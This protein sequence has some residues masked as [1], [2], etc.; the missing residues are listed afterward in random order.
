MKTGLGS[1]NEAKSDVKFD[2]GQVIKVGETINLEVRATPGHTE[3]CITYVGNG[4]TLE[5]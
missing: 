4:L 1:A 3:G 2:H 5:M